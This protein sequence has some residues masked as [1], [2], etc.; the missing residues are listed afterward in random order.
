MFIICNA[1]FL[2][3]CYLDISELVRLLFLAMDQRSTW[4]D[5]HGIDVLRRLFAASLSA[6]AQAPALAVT[7]LL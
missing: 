2:V 6:P 7:V 4:R 3:E 5:E 1:D